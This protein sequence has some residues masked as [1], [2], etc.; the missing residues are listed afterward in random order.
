MVSNHSST[1]RN[2]DDA[3]QAQKYENLK[4]EVQFD[5]S[6]K[7]MSNNPS[8]NAQKDRESALGAH[9]RSTNKQPERTDQGYNHNISNPTSGSK[10]TMH[11]PQVQYSNTA[12]PA[13]MG[14]SSWQPMPMNSHQ[15]MNQQKQEQNS[16]SGWGNLPEP[17]QPV[18]MH[19]QPPSSHSMNPNAPSYN[20]PFTIEQWQPPPTEDSSATTSQAPAD[21]TVIPSQQDQQ[22]LHD[23]WLQVAR[24][25]REGSHNSGNLFNLF[26][27]AWKSG[28]N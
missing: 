5:R 25:W 6:P 3:S 23:Q 19:H 15:Q 28:L 9:Q 2:E 27:C 16:E 8:T 7:R 1:K 10:N 20:Q 12:P 18:M 22:D 11:A 24:N 17:L 14:F 13:D 21:P 4:I 26:S